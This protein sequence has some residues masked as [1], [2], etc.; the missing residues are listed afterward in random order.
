MNHNI[1]DDYELEKEQ[2][3]FLFT[4]VEASRNVPGGKRY[5]FSIVSSSQGDYLQ[6]PGLPDG[7]IKFYMTDLIILQTHGC[8]VNISQSRFD[9]HPHGYK[10]YEYLK[11]KLGEP[12]DQVE[13]EYINYVN[14][15]EFRKEYSSAYEKWVESENLLW[16]SDTIKQLTKIGHLSR[17]AIIEFIDVLVNKINPPYIDKQK[18]KTKNRLKSIIKYKSENLC[19]TEIPFLF[20]LYD[21]WEK[22]SDLIQREE[23]GAIKEGETLI[24]EDGRRVIFHTMIVMYELDRA[25]S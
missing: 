1:F 11:K 18:D 16:E 8:I 25:L 5:P 7:E 15:H 10:Y 20:A 17:E 2:E 22:I 14:S 12:I 24:W 23:H 6:H 13:K 19:K 21:Y 3:K 9:I 4:I